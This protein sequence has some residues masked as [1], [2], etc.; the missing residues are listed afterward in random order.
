[1]TPD[2]NLGKGK[3]AHE[4]KLGQRRTHST[5]DPTLQTRAESS[6]QSVL[7]T[8]HE[9]E[10]VLLGIG[11]PVRPIPIAS[12]IRLILDFS[13]GNTESNGLIGFSGD[14]REL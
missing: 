4:D 2:N 14:L 7:E 13:C 11:V 8:E 10:T 12:V 3:E 9:L 5:V 6:L 1:M